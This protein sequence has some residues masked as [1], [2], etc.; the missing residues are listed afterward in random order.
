MSASFPTLR[1]CFT[2]TISNTCHLPCRLILLSHERQ[3]TFCKGQTR[4]YLW[5][6]PPAR[7]SRSCACLLMGPRKVYGVLANASSH[8]GF[9]AN[10]RADRKAA[11]GNN[12]CRQSTTASF[13]ALH[14]GLP[15]ELGTQCHIW[16]IAPA[17]S[18][19]PS[20]APTPSFDLYQREMAIYWS[21]WPIVLSF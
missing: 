19:C 20:P 17:I 6:L 16:C 11:F 21:R 15:E 2:L 3:Q 13:F 18:L 4:T 14:V 12:K 9:C 7:F 10:L 1:F 8:S 5:V